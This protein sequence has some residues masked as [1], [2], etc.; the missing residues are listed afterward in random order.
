MDKR[1]DSFIDIAFIFYIHSC[2]LE[3]NI[4]I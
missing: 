3:K 1:A 2:G 4:I